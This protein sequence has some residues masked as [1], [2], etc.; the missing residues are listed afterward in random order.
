MNQ[1]STLAARLTACCTGG[2]HDLLRVH[3]FH[4]PTL[5]AGMRP[6]VHRLAAHVHSLKSDSIP[7]KR[8]VKTVS[9]SSNRSGLE[10]CMPTQS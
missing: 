3:G 1:A 7:A 9:F 6:P 4:A 5:P 10:G 2:V 8:R